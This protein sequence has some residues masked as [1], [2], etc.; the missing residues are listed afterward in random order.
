MLYLQYLKPKIIAD[1]VF[2]ILFMEKVKVFAWEYFPV[3]V[4]GEEEDGEDC[5]GHGE[6]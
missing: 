2:T 1:D 5:E 4:L 6:N 3:L